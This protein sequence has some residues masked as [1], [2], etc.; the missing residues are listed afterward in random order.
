MARGMYVLLIT[1]DKLQKIPFGKK[2]IHN[3][4]PGF[5]AYVG[6]ALNNLEK[7]IERHRSRQKNLHWHIDYF[8][9]HA[10][11]IDVI[12]KET[13]KRIECDVSKKIGEI[14][15]NK[16]KGFGC[17]DC[18]CDSHLFYFKEN[19]IEKIKKI[20]KVIFI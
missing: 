2:N 3:F 16:V 1:L 4:K 17:S 14:C 10:E 13:D 12:T 5:Y 9:N 7:R 6:S 20:I 18:S 15:D 19:P 11:I 8:L